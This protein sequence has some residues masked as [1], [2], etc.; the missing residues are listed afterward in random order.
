VL[1]K[2]KK[3]GKLTL[4]ELYS[5]EL[6]QYTLESLNWSSS[7]AR[8]SNVIQTIKL[9]SIPNSILTERIFSILFTEKFRLGSYIY[10]VIG[11]NR[12]VRYNPEIRVEKKEKKPFTISKPFTVR[13]DLNKDPGVIVSVK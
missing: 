8:G 13:V 4:F 7:V 3:Y 1:F 5:D 6:L 9:K 10:E 12:L 2:K 11:S